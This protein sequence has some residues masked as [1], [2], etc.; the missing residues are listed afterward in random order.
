MKLSK[1][2]TNVIQLMR[3]GWTIAGHAINTFAAWVV[4]VNP[5]KDGRHRSLLFATFERLFDLK[6]IHCC[7]IVNGVKTY[8]LTELG[9]SIPLN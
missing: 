2:Q 3:D 5:T 4:L 7:G 8:R 1:T 9:K 6:L